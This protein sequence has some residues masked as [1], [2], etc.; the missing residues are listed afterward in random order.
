MADDHHYDVVTL[1]GLVVTVVLLREGITDPRFPPENRSEL[2]TEETYDQA[3]SLARPLRRSPPILAG[4]RPHRLSTRAV[5]RT[6]Q[7]QRTRHWCTS[8]NMPR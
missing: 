3:R 5:H 7:E 8:A 2:A 4:C 6:F 1:L